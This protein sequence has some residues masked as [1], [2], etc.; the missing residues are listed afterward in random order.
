MMSNGVKVVVV[1]SLDRLARDLLVQSVLLSKL[2]VE[3]LTLIAANTG[4][5]VTAAMQTEPT[6][7]FLVQIQ[8]ALA[9]LDK[10]LLVR[11]LKRGR[12]AKRAATGRCEGLGCE[13]RLRWRTEAVTLDDGQVRVR[14]KLGRGRFR[15]GQK[16]GQIPA[17]S[18]I[19]P[20][21]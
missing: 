8:G 13:V 6:R 5:D 10:S 19:Q 15:L 11:K 16:T 2:A 18:F 7:K 12:E 20:C 21:K 17:T 14:H 3:G 4:E 9:E 1:E